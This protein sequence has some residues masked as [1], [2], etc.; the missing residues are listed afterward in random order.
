MLK[1][2]QDH[3]KIITGASHEREKLKELIVFPK[4]PTISIKERIYP[5]VFIQIRDAIKKIDKENDTTTYREDPELKI[6]I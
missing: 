2:L 6:I 3:N 1:K 5:E 4:P